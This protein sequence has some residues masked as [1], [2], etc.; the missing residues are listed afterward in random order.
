MWSNAG[1]R[2]RAV[3]RVVM[4]GALVLAF[5]C[6]GNPEDGS[7]YSPVS[8]LWS[9]FDEGVQENT[10]GTD[11]VVTDSDTSFGLT[12]HGNGTFTV[13]QGSVEEDFLCTLSGNDF[14]CPERLSGSS[15]V[16]GYDITLHYSV[17]ITGRLR[18]DTHMSGRQRIDIVC[19][20]SDCLHATLAGY[21]LPCYYS[22]DFTAE[23]R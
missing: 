17:S 20:G 2:A 22:V 11:D 16:D 1:R 5:G 10:C 9:Y 4:I 7:P 13:D 6:D 14:T 23:A 19:E 21:T 15:P 8:G 3:M 12:N 18:S